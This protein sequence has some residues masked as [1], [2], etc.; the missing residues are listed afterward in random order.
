MS[1]RILDYPQRAI[2]RWDT[3]QFI[4][5]TSPITIG[6][7]AFH[8]DGIE[9]V[10]FDI[11]GKQSGSTV[12]TQ[13]TV[14]TQSWNNQ[15]TNPIW[16]YNITFDPSQWDDGKVTIVAHAFPYFGDSH[17]VTLELFANSNG[18][19]PTGK[20]I[21]VAGTTGSDTN[22]GLTR[23]TP[24][25]TIK[26]AIEILGGD[27]GAPDSVQ[28]STIIVIEAG[29]YSE[30]LEPWPR[31]DSAAYE[32]WITIKA[33]DTLPDESVIL[34]ADDGVSYPYNKFIRLHIHRVRF[35][36]IAFDWAKISQIYGE[37]R[38]WADHC[39]VISTRGRDYFDDYTD[40]GG[41]NDP[42]A[43]QRL[44]FDF[45]RDLSDHSR[46]IDQPTNFATDCYAHDVMYGGFTWHF[47]RDNRY[48]RTGC[49]IAANCVTSLNCEVED[50]R[51][52]PVRGPHVDIMQ[53]WVSAVDYLL[54]HRN[55]VL[56]G[57]RQYKAD[58]Q[59][60]LLNQS[61]AIHFDIAVF[62][63]LFSAEDTASTTAPLNQEQAWI[64]HVLF[65]HLTQY[66]KRTLF[67]D[68]DS[69]SALFNLKLRD[70]IWRNC[71]IHEFFSEG[72]RD[73]Y[74][75]P[76]TLLV[77]NSV[78]KISGGLTLNAQST[79]TYGDGKF[80]DTTTTFDFRPDTGSPLIGLGKPIPGV[81]LPANEVG[82]DVNNP[83]AGAWTSVAS[84]KPTTA[85]FFRLRNITIRG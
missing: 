25:K 76:R 36:R 42:S 79:V 2:I 82:G 24:V 13:Q 10:R 85:P 23:S 70:M 1:Y 15:W 5:V 68:L 9:S 69:S 61:Y 34:N 37:E 3:V 35:Y 11:T 40:G 20:T 31:L 19:L 80:R 17:K 16:D 22:D 26:R 48:V 59:Q 50:N 27:A 8:K 81:V 56:F 14:T 33:D 39:F 44:L 32:R 4:D 49:D 46:E 77:E 60:I 67:R 41:N 51:D 74:Q 57:L 6:V 84:P 66:G 55:V 53:Y 12:T 29:T 52:S 38:V 72:S 47:S 18:T 75:S 78:M 43:P 62:N 45:F 30:Y 64:E 54:H 71:Y 63:C 83:N 7:L 58:S 21:Y 73:H 65:M 28:A